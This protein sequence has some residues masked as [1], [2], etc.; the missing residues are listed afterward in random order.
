MSSK[1]N[2]FLFALGAIAIGFVC[3]PAAAALLGSSGILGAAGTGTMIGTLSGAALTS[4]SLC[5]IGGSVF[6][7][8][9]VISGASGVV[10]GGVVTYAQAIE[11]KNFKKA[12]EELRKMAENNKK[13]M[14]EVY[15]QYRDKMSEEER[16]LWEHHLAA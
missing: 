15:K 6:A 4:S 9:L 5:A 7:G 2:P 16:V 11:A 3:A 8:T 1:A 10:V 14:R 13:E 12:D